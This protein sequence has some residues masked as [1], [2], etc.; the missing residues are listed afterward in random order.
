MSDE[1][2]DALYRQLAEQLED[3]ARKVGLYIRDFGIGTAHPGDP[4][5]PPVA[6]ASFLIG[7][8]AM[9]DRVQDPEKENINKE[10]HRMGTQ[11]AQEEF[12]TL[13][14]KLAREAGAA[15]ENEEADENEDS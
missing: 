3:K 4:D 14:E 6:I 13:R 1:K 11:L 8:V 10:V 7:D 15:T 12:E 9:S 2:D 5:A